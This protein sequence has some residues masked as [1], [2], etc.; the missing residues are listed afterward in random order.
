MMGWRICPGAL[1]EPA[2]RLTVASKRTAYEGINAVLGKK[3]VY[4][5]FADLLMSL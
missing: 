5:R 4:Y 2:K 3:S 1:P